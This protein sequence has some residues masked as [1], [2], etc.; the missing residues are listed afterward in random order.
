MDGKPFSPKWKRRLLWI[1]LWATAGVA[2]ASFILFVVYGDNET[3]KSLGLLATALAASSQ[4]VKQSN[5]N[6]ATKR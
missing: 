1:L 3:A 2:M 6:E 4:L 5:A